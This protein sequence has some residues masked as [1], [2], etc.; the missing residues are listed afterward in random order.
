MPTTQRPEFKSEYKLCVIGES[1]PRYYAVLKT[2]LACRDRYQQ[3]GREA[4]LMRYERRLDDYV[5]C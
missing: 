2:A 3:S 4:I 1:E 5:V